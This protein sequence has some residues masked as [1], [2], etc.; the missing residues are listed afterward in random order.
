MK[1]IIAGNVTHEIKVTRIKPQLAVSVLI[2]AQ[3]GVLTNDLQKK[4]LFS[5]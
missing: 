4:S 2:K 5:F 1:V 3:N